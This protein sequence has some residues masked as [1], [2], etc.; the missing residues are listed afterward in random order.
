MK[1]YVKGVITGL[2]IGAVVFAVPV[3][4]VNFDAVLNTVRINVNGV[5]ALQWGENIDLGDGETA[6]ASILYNGTTYLPMRKLGELGGQKVYWNG[7]SKTVSM[8]GRQ[9][10]EKVVAEKPDKNGNVWKYYTFS[11]N[12]NSYL[13]V[14]D[15][16]RGYERVYRTCS[17]EMYITENEIYFARYM[18][19]SHPSRDHAHVMKISFANDVDTQDGEMIKDIMYFGGIAFYGDYIFYINNSPGNAPQNYLYAYNY[20]TGEEVGYKNST[21]I[22]MHGVTVTK[23]NENEL[24]IRFGQTY[25]PQSIDFGTDSLIFNISENTLIRKADIKE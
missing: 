21:L 4:A 12:G 20:V 6:P 25:T 17:P 5:D 7:D 9:K 13:G 15:E 2:L 1:S 16:A 11:D 3:V 14:K 22:S 19:P 18:R 23:L 8:T 24:K 10:D